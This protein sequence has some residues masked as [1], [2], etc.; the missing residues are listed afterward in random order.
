MLLLLLYEL[1]SIGPL[2]PPDDGRLSTYAFAPCIAYDDDDGEEEEEEEKEEAWMFCD[3]L[4]H[5][6]DASATCAGLPVK[7][8][9][10]GDVADAM[11]L[12]VTGALTLT[13]PSDGLRTDADDEDEDEEEEDEDE[14]DE[15]VGEGFGCDDLDVTCCCCCFC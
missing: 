5:I 10:N 3:V 12:A 9:A 14:D 7:G 13:E 4:I 6:D 1:L 11:E 8:M 2:R 15:F